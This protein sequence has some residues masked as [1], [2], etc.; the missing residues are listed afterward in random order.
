MIRKIENWNWKIKNQNST[1][2]SQ[3][4]FCDFLLRVEKI[5][6][7]LRAI[8]SAKARPVPRKR[9]FCRKSTK[10]TKTDILP[11]S[12]VESFMKIQN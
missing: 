2:P 8:F 12:Q 10:S 7:V 9:A 4:R 1:I 5:E 11:S 6:K 3:G